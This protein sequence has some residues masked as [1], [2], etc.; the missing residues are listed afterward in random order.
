MFDS[1]PWAYAITNVHHVRSGILGRVAVAPVLVT[2]RVVSSHT[3]T[4]ICDA[5][6]VAVLS[7]KPELEDT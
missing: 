7:F 6:K 1:S 3:D 5:V 2:R 4:T